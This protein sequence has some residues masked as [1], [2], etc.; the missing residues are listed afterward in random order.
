MSFK[1]VRGESCEKSPLSC[2]DIETQTDP[3]NI[4]EPG[5]VI[6]DNITIPVPSPNASLSPDVTHRTSGTKMKQLIVPNK[7]NDVILN[8]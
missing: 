6:V 7:K 3:V 4:V 8:K 2:C 1:V 5:V